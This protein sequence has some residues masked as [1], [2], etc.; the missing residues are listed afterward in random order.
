MSDKNTRTLRSESSAVSLNLEL[1]NLEHA[2]RGLRSWPS[3]SATTIC[4]TK[5]RSGWPPTASW[6]GSHSSTPGCAT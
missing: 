6:L 2:L 3:C 5:R 4:R 1:T